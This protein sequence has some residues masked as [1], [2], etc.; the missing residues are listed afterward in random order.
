MSKIITFPDGSKL[1]FPDNISPEEMGV[2]SDEFWSTREK[3]SVTKDQ[4]PDMLSKVLT[5]PL[6]K[7]VSHG[8]SE[9]VD[10]AKQRVG[11]YVKNKTP[12]SDVLKTEAKTLGH[13]FLEKGVDLGSDVAMFAL[14]EVKLAGPL[15]KVASYVGGN[16]LK[17]ANLAE[18]VGSF[19]A[20]NGG[21]SYLKNIVRGGTSEE[22]A[23]EAKSSALISGAL[24]LV[25][26]GAFHLGGVTKEKLATLSIPDNIAKFSRKALDYIDENLYKIKD[27]SETEVSQIKQNIEIQKSKLAQTEDLAKENISG[28]KQGIEQQK[29]E[30]QQAKLSIDDELRRTKEQTSTEVESR[31]LGDIRYETKVAKNE[32]SNFFN[33]T[34]KIQNSGLS[35]STLKLTE[36]LGMHPEKIKNTLDSIEN[37]IQSKT[38]ELSKHLNQVVP[39]IKNQFNTE[40]NDLLKGDTGK[41]PVDIND[42]LKSVRDTLDILSSKRSSSQ[43]KISSLM[44]QLSQFVKSKEGKD[45]LA[46]LPD[47]LSASEFKA[48]GLGIGPKLELVKDTVPGIKLKD[49]HYIKQALNEWGDSLMNSPSNQQMGVALKQ[50]ASEVADKIDSQ[51]GGQ[52]ADISK[53]YRGFKQV[54]DMSKSFLGKTN[55]VPGGTFSE[56]GARVSSEMGKMLKDGQISPEEYIQNTSGVMRSITE[57]I[58]VL[59]QN[60]LHSLANDIEKTVGNLKQNFISKSGLDNVK[61][62]LSFA[63]ENRVS[64]AERGHELLKR[65]NE[66]IYGK[67]VSE[68]EKKLGSMEQQRLEKE[69]ILKDKISAEQA[70]LTIQQKEYGQ[71]KTKSEEKVSQIKEQKRIEQQK[72]DKYEKIIKENLRENKIDFSKLL[73]ERYMAKDIASLVP[74]MIGSKLK[75]ILNAGSAFRMLGATSANTALNGILNLENK[76]SSIGLPRGIRQSSILFLNKIR[77][78]IKEEEQTAPEVIEN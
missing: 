42:E 33:K 22:A 31:A 6:V 9:V 21:I 17:A 65:N 12:L 48:L 1:N 24:D 41:V 73:S 57:Q 61:N 76:L 37:D 68:T 72:L 14:P 55:V 8:V 49:A 47:R 74:G 3:S 62:E 29:G 77:D 40:Y 50:V 28:L 58:D 20:L 67:A 70:G 38:V 75:T 19:S 60:G 69:N 27:L 30:F 15:S 46:S 34:D 11:E 10:N 66:D 64:K 39:K 7:Q 32:L 35:P 51:V 25:T 36:S 56:K 5:S 59:K 16:T 53:R 43:T 71:F 52:Y 26:R 45:V 18:K 78:D 13:Q 4:S 23:N 44:G 2:A 63:L 54:E